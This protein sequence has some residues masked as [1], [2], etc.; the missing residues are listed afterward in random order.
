MPPTTHAVLARLVANRSEF[1]RLVEEIERA[2]H[3]SIDPMHAAG[4]IDGEFSGGEVT[5]TIP[6][7]VH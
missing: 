2:A 1:F 4:V 3:C 6:A 7:H 5:V